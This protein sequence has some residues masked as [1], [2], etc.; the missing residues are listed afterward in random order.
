MR[1]YFA[2]AEPIQHL[3][4]LRQNNVKNILVSYFTLGSSRKH[5]K[6]YHIK[7]EKLFVDSGAFS[8]VT[9]GAE[10]DI[11]D[12]IKFVKENLDIIE[13]YAN[14]D[15]IG[16]DKETYENYLKMKE[17]GL[18]PLPVFHQFEDYKYLELY[19]KEC[20]YVALGGMVGFSPSKLTPFLDS[21]FSIIKKYWPKKIHGFGL[22]S[23]ILMKRYPFYSVDSTAWLF[24]ARKGIIKKFDKGSMKNL[25]ER[26]TDFYNSSA[27]NYHYKLGISIRAFQKLEK[28]IT[29]LWK[30]KG[31]E[32]KN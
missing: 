1:L 30:V 2:G 4:N 8:A 32:W 28:Y 12:Y 15:V 17:A 16:K 24:P 27:K 9:L 6:R 29:D 14:L 25:D 21:S 18:N 23:T 26:Y 10:I 5:L 22:T 20:D 3:K 19:L 13:I 11:E 31:I 7:N